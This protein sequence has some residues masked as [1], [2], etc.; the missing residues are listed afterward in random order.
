MPDDCFLR[1]AELKRAEVDQRTELRMKERTSA[2]AAQEQVQ[3][4]D[5]ASV[6]DCLTLKDPIRILH[7]FSRRSQLRLDLAVARAAD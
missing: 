5:M 7:Q 1:V 4:N 6:K 2:L 3:T